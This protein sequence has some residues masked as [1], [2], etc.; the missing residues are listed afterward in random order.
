ML[1]QPQGH[2]AAGRMKSIE[3]SKYFI[4]N[5]TRDLPACSI[6]PQPTTLTCASLGQTHTN[7]Q[8]KCSNFES[9]SICIC[10]TY[11]QAAAPAPAPA[12]AKCSRIWIKRLRFLGNC[13]GLKQRE[14]D[15]QHVSQTLLLLFDFESLI[16]V[17][18]LQVIFLNRSRRKRKRLW[19]NLCNLL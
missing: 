6:V 11:T 9:Q 19:S 1:S 5:R 2:S 15:A 13:N 4:F 18:F 8:L 14:T 17:L 7:N 10:F 16:F 3:K 12:L